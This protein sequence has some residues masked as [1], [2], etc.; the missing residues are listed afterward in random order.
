M[1]VTYSGNYPIENRVGEIERLQIQGEAMAPETRNMFALIGVSPGWKCLDLGCGP[2]G[3][4]RLMSEFVGNAGTVVGLDMDERFLT[5]A[6]Q[7]APANVV[8]MHG[9]AYRTG[10]PAHSFDLVH[11]RFVA[12]TAGDPHALIGEAVRLARPGGVVALQEPDL[13]TLRAHPP[14]PA[15][16]RLRETLISAFQGVG[17]D[18]TFAHNLYALAKRTGLINVTY[19]PFLLGVRSIDP[20]VDYLP[21]TVESIRNTVLR[22]GLAKEADLIADLA[23]CRTHLAKPETVFTMFTVVQVWGLTPDL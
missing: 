5:Y 13:R 6:R 14:H 19:R 18:A 7:L 12:G 4:T 10:L 20:L 23:A 11:M 9:D 21:S 15:F 8:F 17:A 3:V 2:E 22:L 1:T 16:D